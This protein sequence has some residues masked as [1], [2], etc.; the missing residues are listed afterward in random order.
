MWPNGRKCWPIVVAACLVALVGIAGLPLAA[1]ESQR[2]RA[3]AE[4]RYGARGLE[5]VADWMNLIALAEDQPIDEKL[6]RINEFFNIR[7]S[8]QDDLDVWGQADYWATPLEL[9]GRGRGD[10]EDYAIAKYISLLALGVPQSSLRLIY[11]RARIAGVGAQAHMVLG[12]YP[13]P[14][15]EPRILDNLVGS[16][17][18]ASAR[19]D[20]SPVFSFNSEGLWAGGVR[21]ASDPTERLSRWRDVLGRLRQEGFL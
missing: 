17:E 18:W 1:L 4:E 6:H 3:V 16:I 19:S 20:L 5:S 2:L 15:G 7:T 13:D 9:M 21:A 11:V 14:N 12:Y 10:C 8:F